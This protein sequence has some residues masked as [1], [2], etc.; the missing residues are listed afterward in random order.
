MLRRLKM[1]D[2]PHMME[3]MQ[4]EQVTRNYRA[5]FAETTEEQVIQFIENSFTKDNQNFAFVDEEDT[6]LGTISLKNI[7]V[8]DFNAEYAIVTRRCA[9]GTGAAYTATDEIL[10]Y[11]F[12]E[13]KLQRVYLNVLEEN[14]RANRFYEKCGFFYEGTFVNHLYLRNEF[15]N[16]NWY[17]I[18]KDKFWGENEEN[19]CDNGCFS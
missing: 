11:A 2:I 14:K 4:D 13:L 9:Q 15:K 16:L 18:T 3:W 8:Q 1:K 12:E 7:S 17:G 6:Y 5:N 19:N 10:K